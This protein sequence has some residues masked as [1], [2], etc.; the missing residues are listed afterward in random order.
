MEIFDLL[1]TE[2]LCDHAF[3]KLQVQQ[4]DIPLYPSPSPLLYFHT[5]IMP[6]NI[7]GQ[8]MQQ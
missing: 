4:E 6:I 7:T 5:L 1:Y 2:A 3:E 8:K